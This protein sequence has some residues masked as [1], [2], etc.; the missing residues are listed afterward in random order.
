MET[1]VNSS[2]YACRHSRWQSYYTSNWHWSSVEMRRN[3]SAT[4]LMLIVSFNPQQLANVYL[5][6]DAL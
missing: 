3:R 6:Y 1:F 2:E 4:Q 5:S